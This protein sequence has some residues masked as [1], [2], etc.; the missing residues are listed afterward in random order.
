MKNQIKLYL[1]SLFIFLSVSVL[2]KTQFMRYPDVHKD[3]IVFSSGEDLWIVSSK[4]GEAT[5]L[6]IH[7]GAEQYPRFSP[8]GNLIAFTAS[9]DGNNDVYVMNSKGGEIT[10]VTYHPNAD[11][12]IGW[13]E[14]KNKIIFAS[15]RVSS[16][17]YSKLFLISPDGSGLEE[18]IMY[19]ASRGSFSPDGSKIAYNKTNRENRTWKRYKG[20][21]AQEIYIYDLKSNDIENIS[22]YDGTDRMPMWIGDEIYYTSDRDRFLNIYSYNTLTKET[23]QIT[24]HN[25]FDARRAESGG[26]QIVY[27][28][29]GRIWLLDTKTNITAE[30]PISISADPPGRR[31]YF[32][33]VKRQITNI[34]LSPSG[35]RALLTARGEVFTV[36]IK[37]G[38]IR[39]LSQNDGASDKDAVWSPDGKNVAYFSD[40]NGEF[41]LYIQNQD[42]KS[43]AIKLT[44]LKEGYRHT[45]RWSP[46]SKMLAF[47]DQNLICYIVNVESKKITKVDQAKY[48]NVDI[49]LYNK[50]IND[51]KWSP[52]SK[53]LTYSRMNEAFV[54]QVYIYD[55]LSKKVNA[56]SDGLFHDFNPVFSKNGEH[57]LF[58]SNRTFS[59][60]Y[61]DIEW[62]MVYKD[63]AGIY[64]ITLRADGPSIIP[65]K[66]DEEGLKV[67]K[68]KTAN[69][70]IDFDGISERVEALPL[71]RGNYR[72]L[73]INGSNLFYLNAE[74]GDFNK[75][76]YRGLAPR[77]LYAYS[78]NSK[79]ETVVLDGVDK[80]RLSF[81]GKSLIFQ[82]RRGV[83]VAPAKA[84][85]A[86]AKMLNLS[87]LK[88]HINPINEWKAVF[89][90]A[91][92]MER[93]FYYEEN[94]HGQ[95]W[96][97]MHAKY[98]PLLDIAT[99]RTDVAYIIGELIGELNSSHTYVM[100]GRNN[101]TASR[102]SVGML[103][104]NWKIDAK[105]N[106]YQFEKIFKD[107]D[108]SRHAYP[109]LGKPGVNVNENDYLLAVNGVEVKSTKN[110]YSY[111]VDLSNKQVTLTVNSKP[112]F[113]GSHEVVVKPVSSEGRLRYINWLEFNRKT[114]DKASNGQIGYIYLPDTYN[115]S[116]TDFPRYFYSQT[117]KKGLIIDG[118]FNGGG[119]DPEIFLQR[120]Q[121]K[122]HGYWTR[123]ASADQEIPALAVTAHMA[124]LTNRYAGSGGDE[125][126]Y[127][128]QF[129]N[130]GPVIG[131]RTW[132]GL[133]G[134]SMFLSLM[135]GSGL[136]APDYRIYNKEGDW[137]V[138]NEGVTPDIILEQNS[139]NMSKG[140]DDQ[141]MKA[142]EVLLKKI[143]DQP[144]VF[145]T[146]KAY[147]VDK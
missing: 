90:E 44:S 23:K 135:D 146:H 139:L 58:I 114:I 34:D 119:L 51:F 99:C 46:D 50:P 25:N 29:G 16:S 111:F 136:T 49:A 59:P 4:G 15:G 147:K 92:R 141:M 108:W 31:P 115:G 100:G 131:T 11:E 116:A 42:G 28:Q 87:Q 129:N 93:D 39:N 10:R 38:A 140:L 84:A 110:V 68:K 62:E 30:V 2:A 109:P 21:R 145:P 144:Y 19:D 7:D 45:T 53:F 56:V 57:L 94:M 132:G 1:I 63:I 103:G 79:K 17:R 105:N 47:T 81:D 20:G 5:R 77:K 123:R 142:V 48:E 22:N 98:S 86:K 65:F 126:P 33:D 130:M 125:L 107:K 121:K 18:L 61:C 13:H 55:L 113:E 80:F 137:V 120:L 97:F 122:P 124:L 74:K 40:K 37:E 101:R 82:N 85:K 104:V 12:V 83:G 69:S 96:D 24:S 32:R 72:D 118:R 133:I 76:D 112:S 67:K 88:I 127:E 54:Y 6:T 134:V 106:R 95:D 9:Y 43:E 26:D 14:G 64:A 143:K 71:K 8:D 128:F 66:S 52:D 73:E 138:E 91:W 27:E 41:E 36:P 89:N 3:K 117:K 78:F 75:M 35:K 70:H 102:V 60:T